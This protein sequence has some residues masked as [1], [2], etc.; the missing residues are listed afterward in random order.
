MIMLEMKIIKLKIKNLF[1]EFNNR[2]DIVKERI[3]KFSE[4]VNE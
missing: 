4:Y 3:S 1:D 2:Y